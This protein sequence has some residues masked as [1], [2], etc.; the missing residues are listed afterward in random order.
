MDKRQ[1]ISARE[2]AALVG[3]SKTRVLLLIK[4]KRRDRI[5]EKIKTI[6]GRPF[7]LVTIEQAEKAK[8]ILN[9]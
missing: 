4:D 3:L 8:Q 2:Y 7:I 1:Y 6:D 9:K 5:P